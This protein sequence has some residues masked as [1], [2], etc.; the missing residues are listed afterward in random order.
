[1]S[2]LQVDGSAFGALT[3][4]S[5]AAGERIGTRFGATLQAR[6]TGDPLGNLRPTLEL[7]A[8]LTGYPADGASQG[9]LTLA[10]RLSGAWGSWRLDLGHLSRWVA[11][12]SPF[13]VGVDRLAPL[14]RSDLVATVAFG[15]AALWSGTVGATVRWDW[16]SDA[17]RPGR[18]V[19]LERLD[20]RVAAAGPVAG[21]HL[22]VA[23]DA[24]LAG[25]LD[26]RS[27]RVECRRG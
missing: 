14:H 4:Q 23:G 26:P 15:D 25:L 5:L 27:G 13:G 1:V 6:V 10:P 2:R 16:R 8:G 12:A 9:W 24:I 22:A 3:A 17:Q 11:G 7:T 21:G 19:G 20:L 18:A